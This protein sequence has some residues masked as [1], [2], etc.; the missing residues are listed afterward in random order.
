MSDRSRTAARVLSPSRIF[1]VF[2]V[3][4]VLTVLVLI[5][6]LSPDKSSRLL[7]DETVDV[8]AVI[9]MV[10][11][12][13]SGTLA[14]IER[15]T[16]EP[17]EAV[18]S[19]MTVMIASIIGLFAL[20]SIA[21][22]IGS[23]WTGFAGYAVSVLPLILV[24]PF[25]AVSL[26]VVCW[27]TNFGPRQ[28][29]TSLVD[30]GVGVMG[31]A[32]IWV[33]VALP[34]LPPAEGP[35][36]LGYNIVATV[37]QVGLLIL[38]LALAAASHH[39]SVLPLVQLILLQLAILVYVG[40]VVV[41]HALR[42]DPSDAKNIALVGYVIAAGLLIYAASR[43]VREGEPARQLWLRDAWSTVIPLSPVA[44][45]TAGLLLGLAS[46]SELAP[47]GATAVALI[48]MALI[49]AVIW[50]RTVA[51]SANR[52]ASVA[53][54]ASNL[55]QAVEQAWFR[56]L[57]QHSRELVLVL[58][59]HGSVVYSSPAVSRLLG[60]ENS[61][62]FGR[63]L[64]DVLPGIDGQD[65]RIALSHS[66]AQRPFP[67]DV[68]VSDSSGVDRDLQFVVAS[69][70][71]FGTDGYVLTGT[72]LTDSR[73]M[74][75]LLG[76]S[77]RRDSL[78]GLLNRDT[79]VRGIAEVQDWAAPQHIA[80]MVV[81]L[82][83]FRRMNDIRGHDVGDA[84]LR[85]VAEILDRQPGPIVAVS[86]LGGDDFAI[87]LRDA[88]PQIAAEEA[89]EA[90]R[91]ALSGLLLWDGSRI[92]V[93]AAFGYAT[94]STG[95]DP[96]VSLLE[97][98]N[99]AT[100]R[101]R[102]NPGLGLVRYETSMREALLAELQLTD[103]IR[104]SLEAGDFVPHYQPIID[105]STGRVTGVEA[106]VRRRLANG[107]WQMPDT[108]IPLAERVG[109]VGQVDR[110]LR[111]AVF[112]DMP[113]ILERWPSLVVS[114]N[115]SAVEFSSDLVADIADQMDRAGVSP[116]SVS[117]EVTESAVSSSEELAREIL[118]GL[119]RMSCLVALDDFGTGYSSL[120]GLASMNVDLLKIDKSFVSDLATSQRAVSLLRG[121][122]D[123]GRALGLV[124]IAEGITSTE[125]ADLIRGM[126]CDRGQGFLYAEP[127]PLY[128]LVEWMKLDAQ[129]R[130]EAL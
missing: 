97:H 119:H 88:Q 107:G 62:L 122:V 44:V 78:T 18:K 125:Q 61:L 109:L 81:N 96:A 10:L 75:A 60:A 59:D 40:T 24:A 16:R 65:V 12:T 73:R 35:A 92:S 39:R 70:S 85:A 14:G 47:G 30:T 126:G 25:L 37:V 84:I 23:D 43:P 94:P 58:D 95:D 104:S 99:L 123:L 52:K 77:R 121:V 93:Q 101:S 48:L 21:F 108:F 13:L 110:S 115:L 103:E 63:D 105:L 89:A 106:L 87:L 66:R 112:A 41:G 128:A 22:A 55:N 49:A 90:I 3:A 38:V 64:A 5:A 2:A 91:R 17:P 28:R 45:A 29:N 74:R 114:I 98:A 117:F 7:Q 20:Q 79:F 124:M 19:W 71:G 42:N 54:A 83:D 1:V 51:A 8:L 9:A 118:D 102:S 100:G 127:M 4:V 68:M 32:V 15:L 120:G 130:T 11:V 50:L 53:A 111:K 69:L 56:S 80:V 67:I 57:T 116:T 33:A 27:P 36:Q 113:H 26:T 6:E 72:D 129:D 86:R 46:E 31:L 34:Q 76:E 82:I